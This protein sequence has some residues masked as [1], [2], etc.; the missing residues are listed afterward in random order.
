MLDDAVLLQGRQRKR[1]SKILICLL[2]AL[3]SLCGALL[4]ANR[5]LIHIGMVRL[6]QLRLAGLKDTWHALPEGYGAAAMAGK[7]LILAG[8]EG[9]CGLDL[10]GNVLWSAAAELNSPVAAAAGEEALV[11]EPGGTVL[12]LADRSGAVPVEI[13]GGADL[14]VP[15]G[16]GGA[17][18]ITEGSGYLTETL[19]IDGSGAVLRRIGLTDRAM[20]M[21]SWL[22]DGTLAG[23]CIAPSGEWQLYL[24]GRVVP[25]EAEM[26]Y[27]LKACGNGLALWTSRGVSFYD[28]RGALENSWTLDA[29]LVWDWACGDYAAA[30]IRRGGRWQLLT[31]DRRGIL[32]S[33]TVLSRRPEKIALA[34]GRVCL[35]DPEA[36]TVLSASGEH[37]DTPTGGG[38]LVL[39]MEGAAVLIGG[40]RMCCRLLK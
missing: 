39:P 10:A 6:E 4:G 27:D 3:L 14:A 26:V 19:V 34:G 16:K 21:A 5:N 38:T 7:T 31:L 9:I 35:L 1:K 32:C 18:V 40:G 11:Y 33:G 30:V 36:L 28:S 20:V 8:A 13:P 22:R 23:C 25:L 29:D 12:W 24:D 2:A 15:D 37:L 17:A